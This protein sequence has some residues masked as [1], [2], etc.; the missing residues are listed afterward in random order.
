MAA[1][2]VNPTPLSTSGQAGIFPSPGRVSSTG[3]VDEAGA[4]PAVVG[5]SVPATVV[6]TV[7]GG[8]VLGPVVD[9]RRGVVRATVGLVVAA[10]VVVGADVVA[11]VEAVVASVVGV[12]GI[13]WA[14][15]RAHTAPPARA[16]SAHRKT[17]ATGRDTCTCLLR[18]PG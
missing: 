18:P 15:A 10:L 2:P 8:V 3:M 12:G 13:T 14:P 1:A 7:V 16:A 4:G 11:T 17:T 9:D 6:G 5:G